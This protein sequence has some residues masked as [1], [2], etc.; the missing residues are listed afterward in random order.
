MSCC[1]RYCWCP[2]D[3]SATSQAGVRFF[4]IGVVGF[5]AGSLGACMSQS[6]AELVIA[7]SIPGAFAALMVPQVLVT[8]VGMILLAGRDEGLR[9]VVHYSVGAVVEFVVERQRKR[10][11]SSPRSMAAMAS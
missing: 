6:G 2:A 7:R 1:S 5:A 10:F 8:G 9:L 4:L 3:D 11:C